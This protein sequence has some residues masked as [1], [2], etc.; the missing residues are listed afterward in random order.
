MTTA[1]STHTE[2]KTE[3]TVNFAGVNGVDPMSLKFEFIKSPGYYE[4]KNI[5][6]MSDKKV[7]AV[8]LSTS[9][10]YFPST[11]SF[12][13]VSDITFVKRKELMLKIS[14]MQ[15]QITTT[16]NFSNDIYDCR[17]FT[18]IP[19]WTG[20]FVTAILAMILMWGLTMIMDIRTM[21]R[22]DDPKGKTIA[23][24]AQD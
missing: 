22:F 14:N 2:D 7:E 18:S 24:S 9:E 10:V 6:Y 4:L 1:S 5:I 21:D 8:L 3:L 12:R 13:C 15:L 11:Y 19:I 16:G 23:I 20:L 17:G